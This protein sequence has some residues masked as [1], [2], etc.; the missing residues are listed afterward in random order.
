MHLT[1]CECYSEFNK[2]RDACGLK[3]YL[4]PEQA[5]RRVQ[6]NLVVIVDGV[7]LDQK[8]LMS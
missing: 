2:D 7:K 8:A 3:V 4:T 1:L 6:E 5:L